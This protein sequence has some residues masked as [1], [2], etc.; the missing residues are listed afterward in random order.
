MAS[1]VWN[2][3][4]LPGFARS[5]EEEKEKPVVTGVEDNSPEKEPE[6]K[7]RIISAEWVPGSKGFNLPIQSNW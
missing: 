3:I 2:D 6:D 7:V 1:R 5:K 4:N